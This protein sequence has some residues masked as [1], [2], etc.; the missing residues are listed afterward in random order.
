[1]RIIYFVFFIFTASS[2][3]ETAK[4]AL[5]PP[6]LPAATSVEKQ[7]TETLNPVGWG[8]KDHDWFHFVSQGSAALPIPYAWFIALEEPKSAS[9][10]PLFG[11]AP[12]LLLRIM[13]GEATLFTDKY[14]YRHRFIE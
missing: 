14:I 9:V 10:W 12:S 11:E 13:G 3:I 4:I 5:S 2:Y 1:M 8:K 6:K 7:Q